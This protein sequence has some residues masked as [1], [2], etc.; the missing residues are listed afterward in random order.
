M[1][2]NYRL[3][4]N[5]KQFYFNGQ[6]FTKLWKPQTFRNM[7][8][9]LILITALALSSTAF[10]QEKMEMKKGMKMGKMGQNMDMNKDHIMMMDGKMQMMQ[11]GKTMSMDKDMVLSN[12]TTVMTDGTMKT[13]SGETMTMK[14]GDI[15]YMNGKMGKMKM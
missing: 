11:K 5:L 8:K 2:N 14:E 4:K 1:E 12:G 15:V 9:L 13:K 6:P 10:S 3:I 7:K